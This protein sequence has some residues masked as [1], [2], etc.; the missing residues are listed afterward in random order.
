MPR[1]ELK[2]GDLT[3][4]IGDN[5]SDGEHRA[6]YNGIW[7][8][9]HRAGKRS[10]F[11]P[12]YAGLNLEHIFDGS[13]EFRPGN[14]FEPRTAPME[15]RRISAHQAELHQ[16]P[17]PATS[18]ESWTRFTMTPPHFVDM[19]FRC[20]PHLAVFRHGYIG[21]FWASYIHGPEDKS[22]YFL[23]SAGKGAPNWVQ[24]CTQEHNDESTVRSIADDTV[25]GMEQHDKGTLYASMSRLRYAD[26]FFYG[27]FENMTLIFMFDGPG[28]IR[29]A[30]SP[31][32]G[33]QDPLRRTTCPAWDFQYILPEYEVGSEYTLRIRLCF[34]PRC[35]REQVM[36]EYRGWSRATE[37]REGA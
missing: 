12:A 26:P 37:A 34:R 5:G 19:E 35:T 10:P 4:V 31:S 24:L 25:L 36:E 30:H 11:V 22:I 6:G 8:L 1:T 20:R 17:T 16:P 23:G 13:T 2:A 33:G 9:R 27:L 28:L 32:G 3:A 7:S 21:L 29:F 15:L 14:F 18:L